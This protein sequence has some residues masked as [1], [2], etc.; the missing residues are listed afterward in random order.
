MF[1]L[2]LSEGILGRIFGGLGGGRGGRGQAGQGARTRTF[3]FGSGAPEGF[4]G[5]VPPMPGQDVQV[6]MPITL[7][8]MAFGTEKVVGVPH[9]GQMEKI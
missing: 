7:H 9:N 4:G 1:D 6:E 8:E 2:G 3:R 5:Q